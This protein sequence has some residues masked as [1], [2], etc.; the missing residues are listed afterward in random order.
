[1]FDGV[2]LLSSV[3]IVKIP[4]ESCKCLFSTRILQTPVHYPDFLALM[5]MEST[6][7]II[8]KTS[9]T[10]WTSEI[11]SCCKQSKISS[12]RFHMKSFRGRWCH[13]QTKTGQYPWAQN[14]SATTLQAGW[15]GGDWTKSELSSHHYSPGHSTPCHMTDSMLSTQSPPVLRTANHMQNMFCRWSFCIHWILSLYNSC[16][17][18]KFLPRSDNINT[19]RGISGV[20]WLSSDLG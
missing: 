13:R 3:L 10:K 12:M 14:G 15:S 5:R 7:K 19:A 17:P 1:M 6:Y 4:W 16:H 2:F 11:F 9:P 20:C 8:F 18:R